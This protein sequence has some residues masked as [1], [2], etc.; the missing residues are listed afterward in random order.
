MKN[1]RTTWALASYAAIVLAFRIGLARSTVGLSL[2]ADLTPAFASFLLLLVP[3]WFFGFGA[4]EQLRNAVRS[5]WLRM[6]LPA[7]LGI[8]YLVFVI[9]QQ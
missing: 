7:L 4:G 6:V 2:G 5:R 3:L 8:P 9:R 1:T